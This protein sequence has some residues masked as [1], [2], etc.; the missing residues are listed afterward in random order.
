MQNRSSSVTTVLVLL[1]V[2]AG[3][4]GSGASGLPLAQTANRDRSMPDSCQES[5]YIVPSI[6]TIQVSGV[7]LLS[8]Y[9][10]FPFQGL[11]YSGPVKANWSSTGG[12]LDIIGSGEQADFSASKTG[13]Y[14]ITASAF[15]MGRHYLKGTAAITVVQ[16]QTDTTA[17]ILRSV[18]RPRGGTFT[19]AFSGQ[20]SWF[21]QFR[22]SGS[23][24]ASFL[25]AATEA[26]NVS[27]DCG[28]NCYPDGFDTLTSDKNSENGIKVTWTGPYRGNFCEK[29]NWKVV[30][31]TGKFAN[32]TGSGTMTAT[33]SGGNSGTY[34]D[35]WAGT[36]NF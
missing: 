12:N 21:G 24:N 28:P 1:A 16:M 5:L 3:C 10:H 11:C 25:R 7:Q 18:F 23:G 9:Y 29:L 13:R 26:G 32:A 6:A 34:T 30:S 27:Q 8:A 17:S 14:T 2:A 19:A 4:G 15:V 22:F 33:C 35:V 31:G 20:Y 36:I